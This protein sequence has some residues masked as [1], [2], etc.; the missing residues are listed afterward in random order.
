MRMRR[1][2]LIS[3]WLGFALAGIFFYPLVVALGSD[4]FYLQWQQRDSVEMA[5]TWMALAIPL[6]IAVFHLWGR[7]TRAAAAAM[8]AIS[9]IPLASFAAGFARQ[10]PFDDLL[11]GVWES[12]EVAI[13]VPAGLVLLAGAVFVRAP[14]SFCRWLRRLLIVLSPVSLVV[15]AALITSASGRSA[16]TAR[17]RRAPAPVTGETGC[18]PML[19]LL[20]DELSFSYLYDADGQIQREF[21]AIGA[22]ANSA[23]NYTSAEAPSGET[24]VSLPAL[25]AARHVRDIRVEDDRLLELTE[26]GRLV[27]FSA[28]DRDGLFAT[29]KRLGFTTEMAG[30]YLPYCDLLGDLVDTCQSLSFYNVSTTDDGFSPANAALTTLV[31]WPRQFPFGVLKNLAFGPLQRALVEDTADF[32]QR[33]ITAAPPLFRFVHYSVPHLPFV[34]GPDGYDPPLNPLRTSPDTG[35]V[36][37]L[38][39]VDRLVRDAVRAIRDA[40]LYES[41]TIVLLSDHGFR[42]GRREQRRLQIPFIAKMPHQHERIDMTAPVQ[43]ETLLK[44]VLEQSCGLYS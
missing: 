13:G 38:Q 29:A 9:V 18:A 43:G 25:L 34:F 44:R 33:P 23:V 14:L 32:A 3:A 22:L 4:S 37:Q 19:A 36:R 42:F 11:K 5:V 15:L 10:L 6:G 26:D 39:Y 21:P 8:L 41:S 16:V 17:A 20:F 7:S 31:L 30:Y 40:G 12:R 1:R 28:T 2:L 27:A 24:L 35:Y